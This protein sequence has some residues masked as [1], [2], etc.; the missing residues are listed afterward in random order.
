MHKRD[1]GHLTL[2]SHCLATC[3]F[4]E[5]FSSNLCLCC[6]HSFG[7]QQTFHSINNFEVI[8]AVVLLSN[9]HYIS[10]KIKWEESYCYYFIAKIVLIRNQTECN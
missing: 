8:R 2:V 9:R 7:F 10:Y 5:P 3:V 1:R 6:L 4:A